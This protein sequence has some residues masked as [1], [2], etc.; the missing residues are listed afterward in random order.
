MLKGWG[1][2]S[3][4]KTYINISLTRDFIWTNFNLFV[5][6]MIHDNYC[7]IWCSS[8]WEEDCLIIS[9]YSCTSLC[10]SFSPW[11][12]AI[13]NPRDF[14]WTNLN[15]LAQSMFHA[16]YQCIP[17]SGSW[18]KHCKGF[19]YIYLYKM[20]SPHGMTI[21]CH[22]DFIWTYLN[23]LVQGNLHAKYCPIWCSS[24]WE[25]F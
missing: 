20:L 11:G 7:P 18:E 17:R 14:I 25:Y 5:L 16:K 2:F 10:K 19:C 23:L 9:P 3:M 13:H 8:S 24:S 4:Y 12:G 1:F 15:L 6:G 22:R 21:F